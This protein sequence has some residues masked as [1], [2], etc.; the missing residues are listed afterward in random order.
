MSGRMITEFYVDIDN[1]NVEE[2]IYDMAIIK[3]YLYKAELQVKESSNNCYH[4][5][6]TN[7]YVTLDWALKILSQTKCDKDYIKFVKRRGDFFI[8]VSDKLEVD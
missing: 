8:R 2:L 6:V 1:V 5:I 3:Y 7:V 4:I